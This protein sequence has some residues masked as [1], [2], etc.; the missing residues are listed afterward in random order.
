M[1]S[2]IPETISPVAFKIG[3]FEVL[4]YSISYLLAFLSVYLLLALKIKRDPKKAR[5]IFQTKKPLDSIE[6]LFIFC[7]I[8]LFVGAKLGFIIFYD[9]KEFL[10]NPLSSLSPFNQQ[11]SFTGFSG[12]SFHGA[13]IGI[14]LAGILFCKIKKVSFWKIAN[15]VILVIPLGYFWGRMGNFMNGE[16][17][18]RITES[19]I[20][21][22][23]PRANDCHLGLR[24]PSQL[25]EAFGEGI[26]LFLLLWLSQKANIGKNFLFQLWLILYGFIRFIL[27][28]FRQPD[29]HLGFIWLNFSMGQILSFLMIV[30]GFILILLA[31]KQL[32]LSKT[33]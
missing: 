16:L 13:V 17:Y 5:E 14:L 2:Q 18:G 26:L 25:Y 21:M 32:K 19:S 22:C 31:K 9:L 20:G 8:G 30:L 10:I 3:N 1:W 6:T 27:E 11:G 15:F 4:W 23:F 12:L 28:F 33:L 7:L 24:H 29:A